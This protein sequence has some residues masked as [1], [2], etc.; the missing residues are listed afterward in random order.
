MLEE[1]GLTKTEEK[2]YLALLRLGESPAADIIKKTQ[3][4]RTTVYDV[5]ERLIEKGIVSHITKNKIKNYIPTSPGKFLDIA[6]QEKTQAEKKQE[7]AKKIIRE[8]ES[9]KSEAKVQSLAQVFVGNEG[10]KTILKDIID[11]GEDFFVLGGRGKLEDV[12]PIYTKQWAEKRWAR[13]I[14]AKIIEVIG[15]KAPLWKLNQVR[16]ITPEYESP[17]LAF[18]Y[19]NKVALF[20]NED[21]ITIILIDSKNL[22]Q[23]YKNYFNILWN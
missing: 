13:N 10:R 7:D 2:V 5:L 8:I 16:F 15:A 23:S 21:P 3:L 11:V 18:I 22:A 12:E 14:R 9:I 20:V 19:G 17:I 6:T 1:F 4:H